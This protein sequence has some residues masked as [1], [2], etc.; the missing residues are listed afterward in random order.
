VP[1]YL[2]EALSNSHVLRGYPSLR[3]RGEKL[4]S[5][6]AEYRWE[7]APALELA[8]FADAGRVFRAAEDFGLEGLHGSVGFGLRLKSH[9]GVLVRFDVARGDE[10]TRAY[11]RFGPSF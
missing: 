8:L 6:Q 5:L 3:F 4:L 1:F 7:A 2:Q 10:G 11:L 9:E